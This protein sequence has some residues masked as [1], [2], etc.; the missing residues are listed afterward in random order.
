[1]GGNPVQ[2]TSRTF[3]TILAD[4]NTDPE[5]VDK[6]DWW[7]RIWAGIGDVLSVWENATANNAYLRSAFT[8]RAVVDL[9]RLIGY[10]LTE[11]VTASGLVFVD[12]APALDLPGVSPNSLH[13]N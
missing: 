11:Q 3:N 10:E 6:P 2:F 5:L 8:R 13:L 1:M 4:I 9:C 12:L 7:K